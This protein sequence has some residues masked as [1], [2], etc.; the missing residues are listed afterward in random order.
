[1]SKAIRAKVNVISMYIDHEKDLVDIICDALTKWSS[2]NYNPFEFYCMI[3]G[4]CEAGNKI[5]R[6]MD[7]G[8]NKDVID[9]I[10]CFLRSQYKPS[11]KVLH[12]LL[13]QIEISW[14]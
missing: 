9:A 14:V 13:K 12:F 6:L 1:M 8:T 4:K 10:S 2:G 7:V 11:S 3:N 5:A